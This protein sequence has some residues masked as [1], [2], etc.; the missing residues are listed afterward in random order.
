MEWQSVKLKYYIGT[1]I[2]PLSW[3]H[4]IQTHCSEIGRMLGFYTKD[5]VLMLTV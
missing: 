4:D 1:F 5:F 3:S 2:S